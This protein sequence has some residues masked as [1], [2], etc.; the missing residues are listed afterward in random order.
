VDARDAD[1]WSAL[2]SACSG[3]R[4]HV[5][6]LLLEGGAD[7]TITDDDDGWTPLIVAS[8]GGH[9]EVVRVL[10]GHPSGKATI[11]RRSGGK[12][13]LYHACFT[14]RGGVVRALLESGALFRRA[15]EPVVVW[16]CWWQRG[17]IRQGDPRRN[18]AKSA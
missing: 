3:G 10:L 16:V 7:P 12:T 17:L 13:A 1:G 8:A 9:S 4:T 14:G 15:A 5:V 11:N 6:R 18:V 2:W